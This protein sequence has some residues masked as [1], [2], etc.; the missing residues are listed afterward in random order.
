MYVQEFCLS[1]KT[2][3]YVNNRPGNLKI[4]FPKNMLSSN[5]NIL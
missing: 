3:L 1:I 5:T 4:T 2:F